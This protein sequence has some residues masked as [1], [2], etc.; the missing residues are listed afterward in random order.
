[1]L[2]EDVHWAEQP[3]LE[4]IERL[5]RD[6]QGSLVLLLTARPDFVDA[7]SGSWARIDT[8]TIW[9]EPLAAEST[10]SLVDSLLGSGLPAHVRNLVVERAEGNPFF[11]EEVLGSLI[12]AGVLERSNGGWSAADLPPGFEIPDSVQAVL[13]SRIDLLGEP[14]K[15][16]LQAAAV[17]GRVFWTGPV[18]ELVDE[19]EPDLHVLES[20]DLIRRRSGTTLEGEVEYVFKHS[21]T[22][23]VAYGSLTKARRARL[24]ARFGEWIERVGAGRDEH[25]PLLA[26]HFAE[27]VRPEDA[28]V[29]WPD[30]D[31]ELERLRAKAVVWLG[32]AADGAISR[33]EI[34]DALS[35]LKRAVALEPDPGEQGNLWR[36]IGRAQALKYD[37]DAFMEAM[38]TALALADDTEQRAETYAELAFEG[39]VRSGM[40][41]RRPEHALMDEWTSQALAGV[42]YGSPTHVKALLA[43]AFWGLPDADESGLLASE[44]ADRLGDIGLRLGSW[45]ARAVLSFRKGDFE[46]AHRWETRRFEFLAEITDPD[47]VHDLYISTIPTAAALGRLSEARRLAVELDELVARLT[48]HHRVHGVSSKLEVEELVGDWDAIVALEAQTEHAVRENRDTPCVRNARSLLVCALA[49]EWLGL[50]ERSREL[51]ARADEIE[52]EGYGATLATPRAALAL[53]RGELDR[54]AE[55]LADEDWM[56][57]QTW[58]SLPSAATRMDVLAVIGDVA[59]VDATA[60]HVGRPGSYLEPFALRAAGIVREDEAL[61]ARADELFRALRLPWHAG[62]T[63]NLLRLRKLA[64]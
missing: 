11:V 7:G 2:I 53:A 14:E 8:E 61:L 38:Q 64:S 56:Q 41:K 47:L 54:F 44:L 3:L 59:A 4:L 58:F 45:D 13:A 16:A 19:L 39:A 51:E 36:R 1:L 27:A 33:Y 9:L 49:N 32:R 57:R 30:E 50:P 6:V 25:A 10:E 23:E 17:I 37:G 31:E 42:R 60:A 28:D 24:H 22:R 12:D 20:R 15:T 55:L 48:P 5:A 63:E 34:D 46:A 26:H 18:Y 29:A 43:R 40:W 62:Q 35:L 52:N 21:L